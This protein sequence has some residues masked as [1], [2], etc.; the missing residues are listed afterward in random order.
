MFFYLESCVE[1]SVFSSSL[2]TSAAFTFGV[3]MKEFLENIFPPGIRI[4]EF[5]TFHYV[6]LDHIQN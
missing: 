2:L 3:V 1:S 5:P 6:Y 4:L